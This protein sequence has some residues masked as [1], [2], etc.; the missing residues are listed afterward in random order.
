MLLFLLFLFALFA[1]CSRH[2]FLMDGVDFGIS[3]QDVI[4]TSLLLKTV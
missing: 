2:H 1:F 4:L 3:Y